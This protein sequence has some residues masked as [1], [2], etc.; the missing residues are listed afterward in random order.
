MRL[1]LVLVV[2][3]A[4]RAH[5]QIF[6]PNGQFVSYGALL[7]KQC[8]ANKDSYC[9]ATQSSYYNLYGQDR[10]GQVAVNG[11]YNDFTWTNDGAGDNQPWWRVD[12]ESPVTVGMVKLTRNPSFGAYPD[13]GVY[14][15]NAPSYNDASNTKCGSLDAT[16]AVAANNYSVFNSSC[17]GTYRYLFL[18][19]GG[20]L[21]FSEVELF[22]PSCLNCSSCGPGYGVQTPCSD[23]GDTV[24]GPCAPGTVSDGQGG[25]PSCRPNYW[26][27]GMSSENPCPDL[28]TSPGGTATCTCQ[29]GY[30][31]NA[32]S[33]CQPC[34]TCAAG[35]CL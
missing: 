11:V 17:M 35:K 27:P 23:K 25:C 31:W 19:R 14:V 32:S 6:C 30:F 3:F 29:A 15:G 4:S 28:S 10:S 7:T 20:H 18:Q 26:C 1:R 9:S 12:L 24:C 33:Q 22:S 2:L 34:S 5:T 13:Y 8:G 16:K 21:T